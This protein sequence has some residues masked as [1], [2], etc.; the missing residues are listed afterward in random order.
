MFRVRSVIFLMLFSFCLGAIAMLLVLTPGK[1]QWQDLLDEQ[2]RT[3]L[4]DFD[5]AAQRVEEFPQ[6]VSNLTRDALETWRER[7]ATH[8]N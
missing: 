2:K 3:D 1:F 5:Q 6:V 7:A 8:T 4:A